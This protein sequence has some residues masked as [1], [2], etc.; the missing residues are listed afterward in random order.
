MSAYGASRPHRADS[1]GGV[2]ANGDDNIHD[3]RAGRIPVGEHI[4]TLRFQALCGKP[5]F[6]K[7]PNGP[8]IDPAGGMAASAEIGAAALTQMVKQR[9]G[10][11]AAARI[12]GAKEKHVNGLISH[13][14]PYQNY[15][16]GRYSHEQFFLPDRWK[17][18]LD[19]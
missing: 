10:D 12:A 14:N 8:G 16:A 18:L 17:K 5:S 9:F 7:H 6:F 11:D 1:A 19:P 3:R 15:A 4:S 13:E 2:V